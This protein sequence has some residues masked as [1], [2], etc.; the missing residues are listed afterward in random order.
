MPDDPTRATLVELLRQLNRTFAMYEG[1]PDQQSLELPDLE[2]LLIDFWAIKG[3]GVTVRFG[4]GLLLRNRM[5]R[6]V[7]GNGF[8]RKTPR[9]LITTEG[10]QFLVEASTRPDRIS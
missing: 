4:L 2:R 10:K 8:A 9:Y 5:I 3:G 6:R 7:E 1:A